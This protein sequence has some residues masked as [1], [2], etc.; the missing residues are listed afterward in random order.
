L[1]CSG[2]LIPTVNARIRTEPVERDFFRTSFRI[3]PT[4]RAH[5]SVINN[6]RKTSR[7]TQIYL[8]VRRLWLHALALSLRSIRYTRFPLAYYTTHY[9]RR[10]IGYVLRPPVG[11]RANDAPDVTFFLLQFFHFFFFFFHVA[12]VR[13]TTTPETVRTVDYTIGSPKKKPRHY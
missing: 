8:F 10:I 6:S 12:S 5:G 13:S 11:V 1:T 3:S 2:L 4:L 9:A 7:T